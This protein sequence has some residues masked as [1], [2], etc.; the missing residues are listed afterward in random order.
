MT[1]CLHCYMVLHL[2]Q[3][4]QAV[5][6]PSPATMPVQQIPVQAAAAQRMQVQNPELVSQLATGQCHNS[7]HRKRSS[8]TNYYNSEVQC[9]SFDSHSH[10][11]KLILMK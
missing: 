9:K 10:S 2:A 7:T 5:P 11:N 6:A 8:I 4:Q 3:V 1:A